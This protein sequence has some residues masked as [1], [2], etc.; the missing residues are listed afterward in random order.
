MRLGGEIYKDVVFWESTKVVDVR[1]DVFVRSSEYNRFIRCI[2]LGVN[3]YDR[4]SHAQ[5]I[6]YKVLCDEPQAACYHEVHWINL[7]SGCFLFIS[8]A[9]FQAEI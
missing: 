1:P 7:T 8:S 9:M 3:I 2:S 4:M 6:A 5:C